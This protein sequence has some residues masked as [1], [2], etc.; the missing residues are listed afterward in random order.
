MRV[1]DVTMLRYDCA[2]LHLAM[3]FRESCRLRSLCLTVGTSVIG[4]VIA[5]RIGDEVL[6][7]YDEVAAAAAECSNASTLVQGVCV[8]KT[9][10]HNLIF[11]IFLLYH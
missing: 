7:D 2:F 5:L 10:L 6:Q 4:W 3:P 1:P 8:G 9:V 11:S